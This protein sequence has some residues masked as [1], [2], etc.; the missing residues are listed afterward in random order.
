[1]Y[2]LHAGSFERPSPPHIFCVINAVYGQC[3]DG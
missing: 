2:L 1:L 3:P